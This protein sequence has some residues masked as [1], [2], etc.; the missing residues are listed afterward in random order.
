[1]GVVLMKS[2]YHDPRAPGSFGGVDNLRRYSRKRR[3]Q[4]VDYFTG[5]DAY[6]LHKPTQRRFARRRT[7][8][9]GIG[10]LYQIDLVDLSNLSRHNNKY[11]YLLNCIDVFTKRAWS[12]PLK[13]K[14]GH[15]VSDP[16]EREILDD[17]PCI[18]LQSDKGTE[19]V[20]S[21]FQSMLRCRR[22]EFYTSENEDIKAAVV[23]RFN[24]TL[25]E[26]MYRYFTATNTRRYIDILQDVVYAYNNTRHSS[27]KMAPADVTHDN[28]DVVRARLYPVRTTLR[29]W[30]Y[31][32]GDRVRITMQ[33][34]TFQK[35]YIG[36]WSEEIFVIAGRKPTTPVTYKLKDLGGDDIKGS[37]YC[38]ELQ[39]VSKPDDALFDI[40]RIV[41]T[42]K[43]GGKVEY[44]VK[45]RGYP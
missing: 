19:F 21:T 8:S 4:V 18:M 45:W 30:K 20:N 10:D 27:I 24:R 12:V 28:E 6:T 3:K 2:F 31:K 42:R 35:G 36:N 15:E 14:T 11:R 32:V 9:K 26:R 44:L 37:F 41:K 23:E 1:V 22:V 43:R 40:D 16:F 17:R 5:Q 13:T 25:K 34:R 38:Q 29:Q 33:R 39:M 7:Y